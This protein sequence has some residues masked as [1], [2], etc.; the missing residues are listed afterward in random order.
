MNLATEQWIPVLDAQGRAQYVS[1]TELLCHGANY[2]DLAV[3]PHERVALMR[4]LLCIAHAALDGPR[5]EDWRSVPEL[6]PER[7][8][9][10]LNSWQD[11]FDL[12]H[13]TK[14]FLQIATLQ[15]PVKD[16]SKSKKVA[17]DAD[18]AADNG[19]ATKVSKLDF[20]LAT[21]DSSTLFDHDGVLAIRASIPAQLALHLLTYQNFSPGGLISS[22]VWEDHVTA[23]SSSDGPCAVGSMLHTFWR[24]A[25]L[26]ETLHRNLCHKAFIEEHYRDAGFPDAW[27]RPVWEQMPRNIDDTEAISNATNTYLGRLVPLSRLILLREDCATMLLGA[28]LVYKNYN[29]TKIEFVEE[30]TSTIVLRE[31]NKK[32]PRMLVGINP[33]KAVWRELHALLTHRSKDKLG[34]FWA[35]RNT[36]DGKAHDVLVVGMAR[37]QAKV[38][39]TLESVF[40]VPAAMCVVDAQGRAEY[41]GGIIL[42]ETVAQRL[43]WAVERYR[44][45][46]D[47][48]WQGRLK[49]AGAGKS[50]LLHMLRQKAFTSY[51]TAAERNLPLL[52]AC[53]ET[54]GTEAHPPALDAWRKALWAAAHRAYRL[55]CAPQSSRQ[56]KAFAKGLGALGKT[57]DYDNTYTNPTAQEE[58]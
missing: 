14:P 21:G 7:A 43:G 10:Y 20:A 12:F 18:D 29:N 5:P 13:P 45:A 30:P 55:A 3:R 27:G 15:T 58:V 24:G 23:G 49:G 42:A 25:N 31:N 37:A 50:A 8:E 39:D 46:V 44:Q 19:P 32:Q 1:L 6:L 2:R 52:F 36:Q 47:G 56:F 54:L 16:K 28:G 26:L 38:V 4:L 17:D 11:S 40:H 48:G 35:A 34:G 51:W 33:D 53:V 22:V 57:P 41:A 9:A